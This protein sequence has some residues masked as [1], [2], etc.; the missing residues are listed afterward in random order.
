MKTS[1]IGLTAVIVVLLVVA[2]LAVFPFYWMFVTATTSTS[3]LYSDSPQLFPNLG[4]LGSFA[5][6]FTDTPILQWLGNSLIVAGG[7]MIFAVVLAVPTAY[8]MSR[9][10]FRGKWI[11]GLGLFLTQM[12]PEA[13]LVIPLF[14]IFVALGLLNSLLGL[15]LVNAAFVMPVI[16]LVLKG[17]IDAVP[18]DIDEAARVDGASRGRVL[19]GMI[20]PIIAPS[21]AATA[22]IAFFHGW[23]EYVFALT[24]TSQDALHTTSVGLA[25]FIGELTT[26]TQQVM[27][28]AMVYTLPAVV[29]YL[30]LQRFIVTGIAAGSVKG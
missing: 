10:G 19:T 7:T 25:G 24:F 12:L 8:A 3:G 14:S 15:I 16:A 1:K 11:V 17:A 28:V 2:G 4:D 30:L 29:L 18:I 27:A 9:F 20:V 22:V 21:L 23:N 5:A 26:P 6:A 13:V